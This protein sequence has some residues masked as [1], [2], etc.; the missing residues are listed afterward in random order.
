M[1]LSIAVFSSKPAA[2]RSSLL[3]G[4]VAAPFRKSDSQGI[5]GGFDVNYGLILCCAPKRKRPQV[6]VLRDQLS[7][8]ATFL[9]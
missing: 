9:L 7:L 5:P 8:M 3:S 1:V 2:L 4:K 6:G